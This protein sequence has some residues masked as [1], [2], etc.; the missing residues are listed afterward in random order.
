MEFSFLPV[1]AKLVA[2]MDKTILRIILKVLLFHVPG[3]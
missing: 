2:Q 1:Q 3:S